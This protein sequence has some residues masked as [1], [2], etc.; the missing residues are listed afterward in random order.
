[1]A[2]TGNMDKLQGNTGHDFD[3]S[4]DEPNS[5]PAMGDRK[6]AAFVSKVF[7]PK[8]EKSSLEMRGSLS[9]FRA[10]EKE[11]VGVPKK[12]TKIKAAQP[13]NPEYQNLPLKPNP[14][15]HL[16]EYS[17]QVIRPR[18]ITSNFSKTTS[19]RKL[20]NDTEFWLC[21][22]AHRRP[23]ILGRDNEF[24]PNPTKYATATQWT[25]NTSSTP[26]YKIRS[27]NIVGIRPKICLRDTCDDPWGQGKAGVFRLETKSET[28]RRLSV[29]DAAAYSTGRHS[30]WQAEELP[31][32]GQVDESASPE[33]SRRMSSFGNS[34]QSTMASPDKEGQ[35]PGPT[36]SKRMSRELQPL[37][38]IQACQS[39]AAKPAIVA[40]PKKTG[41]KKPKIVSA[42][43]VKAQLEFE[44][45]LPRWNLERPTTYARGCGRPKDTVPKVTWLN[46]GN[47]N[48]STVPKRARAATDVRQFSNTDSLIINRA[49]RSI[50]AT[51]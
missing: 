26:V 7:K 46:A 9:Q 31:D 24:T 1:M 23:G 27:P 10:L 3:P 4:L 36:T 34:L 33:A 21:G 42:E 32:A 6:L 11:A 45:A 22:V 29:P 15:V 39:V 44:E 38:V 49:R 25:P 50:S 14:E 43:S 8:K 13:R 16:K 47:E 18:V 40:K 35:S 12:D 48:C 17:E 37:E 20:W 28:T 41:P 5:P 2:G 51:F 30:L 19:E